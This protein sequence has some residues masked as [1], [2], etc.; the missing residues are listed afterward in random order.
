[1]EVVAARCEKLGI[2]VMQGIEDKASALREVLDRGNIESRRAVY[3]GN[4]V[5]DLPCFPLVGCAVAVAD[6]HPQVLAAADMRLSL[7][8]GHGAVRELC[9]QLLGRVREKERN[10]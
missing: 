2:P 3:V 6:A 9:D 10:D 5:N 4:D 1:N 8:G 7:P